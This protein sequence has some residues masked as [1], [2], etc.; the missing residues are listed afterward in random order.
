MA[1]RLLSTA[2]HVGVFDKLQ[3]WTEHNK[4]LIQ[5]VG[6]VGGLATTVYSINNHFDTR[7][8]ALDTRL[9]AN[10]NRWIQTNERIDETN[11]H[12]S[13]T[14]RYINETNKRI[15]TRNAIMDERWLALRKDVN[16]LM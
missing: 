8:N 16:D 5:F 4:G 10:D 12:I 11:R 2:A 13:E 14:N 3:H 9:T 15:D 7:F 1:K 6:I